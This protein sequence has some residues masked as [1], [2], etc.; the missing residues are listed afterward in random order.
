MRRI[1]LDEKEK[2]FLAVY[3]SVLFFIGISFAVLYTGTRIVIGETLGEN[4]KFITKIVAMENI[5][6]VL[7]VL[8]GFSSDKLRKGAL[9][10]T[11]I[12]AAVFIS[13]LGYININEYPLIIFLI[14]F[15]YMCF[16]PTVMGAVLAESGGVGLTLSIYLL[17]SSLGWAVGGLIPGL[18]IK[19]SLNNFFLVSALALLIATGLSIPFYP[20][21]IKKKA[22]MKEF[23]KALTINKTVITGLIIGSAAVYLFI[24]AYSIKLYTIIVS[25]L[26]YGFILTTIT[27]ILGAS[28]RPLVGLLVDKHGAENI[29][30]L[31]FIGYITLAFIATKASGNILIYIWFTPLYPFYE[32]AGYAML[33]RRMPETLQSTAAGLFITASSFGGFLNIILSMLVLGRSFLKTMLIAIVLLTTASIWFLA[34]TRMEENY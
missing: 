5:P 27:G 23:E 17:S 7:A 30:L 26:K 4:Y 20:K 31:S 21:K 33:S 1:K 6:G 34:L 3:S 2:I 28:I 16:Q 22:T 14:T 19:T 24:G 18:I 29:L 15:F 25:P 9:L 10:Y 8:L 12:P 32:L 13:I 11:G